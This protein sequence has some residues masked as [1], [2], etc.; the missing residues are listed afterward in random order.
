M[1]ALEL[2]MCMYADAYA[3]EVANNFIFFKDILQHTKSNIVSIFQ[4]PNSGMSA[5]LRQSICCT[6][7]IAHGLLQLCR[8]MKEHNL[9]YHSLPLSPLVM[10]EMAEKYGPMNESLGRAGTVT[11]DK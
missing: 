8:N 11:K 9:F 3:E 6:T 7:D 4:H 1:W 5:I 2:C 10:V